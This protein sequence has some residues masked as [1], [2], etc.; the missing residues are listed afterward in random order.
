MQSSE[1]LCHTL[2]DLVLERGGSDNVTILAGRAP[3]HGA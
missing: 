1:Q 2:L 3:G